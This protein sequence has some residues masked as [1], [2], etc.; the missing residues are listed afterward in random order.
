MNCAEICEPC[1][2]TAA[3]K[4]HHSTLGRQNRPGTLQSSGQRRLWEHDL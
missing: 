4:S 3:R 1:I 2:F